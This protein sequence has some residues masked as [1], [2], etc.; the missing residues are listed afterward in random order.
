MYSTL[1]THVTQLGDFAG[2]GT[3]EVDAVIETDSEDIGRRPGYEVQV[4]VILY[5]QLTNFRSI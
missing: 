2:G 5:D 4:E 3:P 1:S